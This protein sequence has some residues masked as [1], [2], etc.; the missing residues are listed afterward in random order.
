MVFE[1]DDAPKGFSSARESNLDSWVEIG[2]EKLRLMIFHVASRVFRSVRDMNTRL[3]NTPPPL[4][5]NL[6]LPWPRSHQTIS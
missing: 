5:T 1:K 6:L 3:Q 4:S 2:S